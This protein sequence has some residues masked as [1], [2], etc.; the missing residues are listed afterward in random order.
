MIC[1]VTLITDRTDGY[2]AVAAAC[3]GP[4]HSCLLSVLSVCGVGKHGASR[5]GPGDII[6]LDSGHGDRETLGLFGQRGPSKHSVWL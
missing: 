6:T 2:I 3:A 4:G 1:D 5:P